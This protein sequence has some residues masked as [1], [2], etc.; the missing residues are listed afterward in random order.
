MLGGMGL[1]LTPDGL[2]NKATE[3]ILLHSRCFDA[4]EQSISLCQTHEFWMHYGHGLLCGHR[5]KCFFNHP[6]EDSGVICPGDG[7]NICCHV[8]RSSDI[9]YCSVMKGCNLF[10][11]ADNKFVTVGDY[12]GLN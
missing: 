5:T 4:Q 9:I 8:Q 12:H 7:E 11:T 10:L 3:E 2:Q 6:T 1:L